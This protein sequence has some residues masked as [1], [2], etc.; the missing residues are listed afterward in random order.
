[1][2]FIRLAIG[3]YAPFLHLEQASFNLDHQYRKILLA[4]QFNQWQSFGLD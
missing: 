3:K 4:M 1:M 2:E